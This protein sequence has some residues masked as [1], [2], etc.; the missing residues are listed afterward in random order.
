MKY[1]KIYCKILTVTKEQIKGSTKLNYIDWINENLNHTIS[2]NCVKKLL[3]GIMCNYI[4]TI[5]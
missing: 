2:K 1:V 3:I 5:Q 4:Q